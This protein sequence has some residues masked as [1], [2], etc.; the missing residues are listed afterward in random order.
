MKC[1]P[2][3]N[4]CVCGWSLEQ[5]YQQRQAHEY[6]DVTQLLSTDE[7][8]CRDQLFALAV[9]ECRS[10][11]GAG[12]ESGSDGDAQMCEPGCRCNHEDIVERRCRKKEKIRF[13]HLHHLRCNRVFHESGIPTVVDGPSLYAGHKKKFK[14]VEA[15]LLPTRPPSGSLGV[16][17]S[18]SKHSDPAR[19]AE[20][21]AARKAERQQSGG[22]PPSAEAMEGTAS[23]EVDPKEEARA[24]LHYPDPASAKGVDPADYPGS[25][26]MCTIPQLL[27][28]INLNNAHSKECTGTLCWR[29]S[30]VTFTGVAA[31]LTGECFVCKKR[32]HW[33]S[34]P[35]CDDGGQNL[36][37]NELLAHAIGTTPVLLEHSV[38]LME[39]LLMNVPDKH[40]LNRSITGPTAEAV[41]QT[42]E[43]E[44][45]EML[46]DIREQRENH[47]LLGIDGSHSGG[48]E[49]EVTTV[50]AICLQTEKVLWSEASDEGPAHGREYALGK[51]LLAWIK[52]QEL[53]VPAMC[54]DESSLVGLLPSL[55]C[56]CQAWS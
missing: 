42:W 2:I 14:G 8:E 44:Q 46:S 50:N 51:R 12:L 35:R 23:P 5:C 4:A 1:V 19:A 33:S 27:T 47:V 18:P 15:S 20:V 49:A 36:F 52:E 48:S 30:D 21:W 17:E 38:Y 41:H 34:S 3:K 53:D 54:M 43:A 11:V 56:A 16:A 40:H 13:A 22:S 31:N 25:N 24:K 26:F 37:L 32:E 55:A 39:A 45:A 29:P 7:T 10:E 28:L 6:G 9:P